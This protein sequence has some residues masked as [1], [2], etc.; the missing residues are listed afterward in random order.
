M[1]RTG[2][3][4]N[5]TLNQELKKAVVQSKSFSEIHSLFRSAKMRYLQEQA[6]IKVVDGT[7]SINEM[8]RVFS[9]TSTRNGQRG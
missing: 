1:G 2:V 5:I 8:L 7:T 3:F 4:E 6:L 9:E